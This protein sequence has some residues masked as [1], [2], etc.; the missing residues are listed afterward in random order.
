MH[1]GSEPVAAG[2]FQRS[3]LAKTVAAHSRVSDAKN[4]AWS[5]YSAEPRIANAASAFQ[6]RSSD[7]F[8]PAASRPR[9]AAD[10]A[11]LACHRSPSSSVE[12]RFH[13]VYSALAT[14]YQL[15][16]HP[17]ATAWRWRLQKPATKGSVE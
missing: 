7:F 10:Q 17:E 8:G 11:A 12:T 9:V 14:V 15:A 2:R 16:A 13:T 3:R 4:R 1:A 5:E 6:R